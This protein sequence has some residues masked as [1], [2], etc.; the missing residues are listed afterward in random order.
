MFRG[1]EDKCLAQ[2]APTTPAIAFAM[3]QL[4][5]AAIAPLLM[6]GTVAGKMRLPYW[7][8]FAV[9]WHLTVYVPVAHA[10]WG[11]GFLAKLGAQDFAGGIV[12]H[13]TAGGSSLILALS[14]G[15]RIDWNEHLGESPP[16]N[17]TLASI[18]GALLFLGW[19]CFNSGSAFAANGVAAS[20]AA[21]TIVGSSVASLVFVLLSMVHHHDDH[22]RKGVGVAVV[23]NGMLAGL[24]GITPASG[25]ISPT[26]AIP[27]AIV[28]AAGSFYGMHGLKHLE[29]DDVLDVSSVHGV[30]GI[31]GSIAVGV[32]GANHINPAGANGLIYGEWRLL[33]AQFTAVVVCTFW[34]MLMTGLFC[35]VIA[36]IISC[37]PRHYRR[38]LR[39][40]A[41]K[42]QLGL[43]FLYGHGEAYEELPAPG[44]YKPP[45]LI[46]EQSEIGGI[47]DGILQPPPVYPD[48]SSSSSESD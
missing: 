16:H 25:Y 7:I 17:L 33:G 47:F 15:K 6:T 20:A 30:S 24:A 43:D 11:D 3:F 36:R 23:L 1:L 29:V 41:E 48:D 40:N 31:I 34:A 8:M 18:G 37:N 26:Y 27:V 35:A 12:L 39:V 28:I 21:T 13:A 22:G 46:K 42:E 19:F 14:L 4:M 10:V 5:F 9:W 45:P 32:F 44:L 2:H 38:H